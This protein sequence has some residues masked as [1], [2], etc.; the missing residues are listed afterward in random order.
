MVHFEP[1]LVLNSAAAAGGFCQHRPAPS[2]RVYFVAMLLMLF[3]A[4]VQMDP[5]FLRNQV[6]SSSSWCTSSSSAICYQLRHAAAVA[7]VLQCYSSI[8]CLYSCGTQ[9]EIV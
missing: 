8:L 3:I 9:R 4:A 2:D 1:W 7:T 5:K 6:R